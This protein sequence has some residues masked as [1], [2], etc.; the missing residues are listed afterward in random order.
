MFSFIL[1]VE[2][3]ELVVKLGDFDI[4]GGDVFNYS[5]VKVEVE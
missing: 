3:G 5:I 4:Y 2:M 1:M